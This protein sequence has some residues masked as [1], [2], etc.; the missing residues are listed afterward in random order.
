MLSK[1]RRSLYITLVVVLVIAAVLAVYFSFFYVPECANYGCFKEHMAKCSKVFYINEEPAASWGYNIRGDSGDNCVIRITL[2]MAKEGELE[3]A[4]FVGHTMDCS[5]PLGVTN[6]PEKELGKC[7][8]LLK[9]DLQTVIIT[10]LHMYVIE[11]LGKFDESIEK[12][13]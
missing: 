1:Y 6:Y 8:G 2:L 9:E 4:K 11:N 3:V 13:V 7:H 5:Y 10:K 12:V